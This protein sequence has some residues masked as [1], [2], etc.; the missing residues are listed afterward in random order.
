MHLFFFT[1][2]KTLG[3]HVV[4]SPPENTTTGRERN[5]IKNN[6]KRQKPIHI[7]WVA[8]RVCVL[9][10]CVCVE[11]GTFPVTSS[12]SR[13]GPVERNR[14]RRQTVKIRHERAN[15]SL[16]PLVSFALLRCLV[17][18]LILLLLS[19]FCADIFHAGALLLAPA[20]AAA[21]AG[22]ERR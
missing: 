22:R 3:F 12:W 17:F 6:N 4:S 19:H 7:L 14:M 5:G 15:Q 2:A 21:A 8:R 16:L 1:M 11:E 9:C 18:A 20:A 10:V 13:S